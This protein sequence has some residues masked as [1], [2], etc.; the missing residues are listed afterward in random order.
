MAVLKNTDVGPVIQVHIAVNEAE[1]LQKMME[2]EVAHLEKFEK[3]VQERRVR[4]T[5]LYPIW[6]SVGY[7]AG[8]WNAKELH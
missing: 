7:L 8:R 3:L 1:V 5:A 4:P 2:Q 6:N